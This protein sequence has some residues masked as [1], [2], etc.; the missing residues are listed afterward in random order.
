MRNGGG[1]FRQAAGGTPALRAYRLGSGPGLDTLWLE[2]HFGDREFEL[3]AALFVETLLGRRCK[4]V[5]EARV[6][7]CCPSEV[8]G[9]LAPG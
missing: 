3:A 5:R 9:E 7:V 1:L 4:P 2:I 8:R 6:T